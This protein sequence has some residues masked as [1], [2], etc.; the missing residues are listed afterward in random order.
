MEG[1]FHRWMFVSGK[2]CKIEIHSFPFCFVLY[3]LDTKSRKGFLM[4]K[5]PELLAAAALQNWS[6]ELSPPPPPPLLRPTPPPSLAFRL[7]LGWAVQGQLAAALTRALLPSSLGHTAGCFLGSWAS[8]ATRTSK[9][10]GLLIWTAHF[11][12]VQS[13]LCSGMLKYD[14]MPVCLQ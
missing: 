2:S 13:R 8:M 10:Q 12:R 1:D 4:P 7:A 3:K 5:S 14:T 11:Y 6:W 9:K